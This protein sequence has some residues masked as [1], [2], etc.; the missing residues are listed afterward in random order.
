MIG[1]VVRASFVVLMI[2]T[3]ALLLP[4]ASV[5]A[6]QFVALAAIFAAGL[7]LFEY[8]A[9]YPGLVEFR[10]APPFN[11][12]RFGAMFAT[13][14]MISLI[15]KGYLEPS[16][17]GQF[18]RAV[19]AVL[20]QTLDFAY[21]P[22]R[23]FILMMPAATSPATIEVVRAAA[24]LAYV[25]SIISLALFSVLIRMNRWPQRNGAFN[26]WVNLPTF[27]PT[28]GGDAVH[29]LSRA[30]RSNMMLG[31]LA[32]FLFPVFVTAFTPLIDPITLENP[33][34]LVWMVTA[35]ALLPSSLIMRGIAIR[36]IVQLIDAQ[37]RRAATAPAADEA[38]QAV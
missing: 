17:S 15:C 35:W 1:A 2:A 22:V 13:V 31:F 6:T 16:T 3:P 36:R 23:L 25:T 10:D 5:D 18:F 19:G 28:A 30:A 11:R 29:R 32:P 33:Q 21:S 20:G 7:V 24:G 14:I 37:R 26:V 38:L 12:I 34:T 27:D 4:S 9:T 8:T